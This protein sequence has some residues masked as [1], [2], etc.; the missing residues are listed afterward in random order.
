MQQVMIDYA[1]NVQ[2]AFDQGRRRRQEMETQRALQALGV[3]PQ[4]PQA[5]QALN[6]FN[7]TAAQDF[8]AKQESAAKARMEVIG[9]AAKEARTPEA[10]DQIA[11]HLSQN[12]FPEAAQFVGKF[13]PALRSAFMAQG[14]VSDDKPQDNIVVI[15]GVAFDKT[16]GQPLF[17]S[18]Y[19]KVVS[20]PGGIYVQ[21]RVG[22]GRQPGQ[23]VPQGRAVD[24]VLP[25]GWK[26]EDEGDASGNAGGGF[27]DPL[28]PL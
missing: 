22:Y 13:S 19:P 23:A 10:W 26:F 5:L 3:N 17:E 4:D 15:D 7:P 1:G 12:G 2:N 9:R 20:G 28:A 27:R 18:P 6:R 21:D 25:P 14:G 24:G 8:K 11:T 16:T